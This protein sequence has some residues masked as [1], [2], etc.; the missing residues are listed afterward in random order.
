[1]VATNDNKPR[2]PL[3]QVVATPAALEMLQRHGRTP[4]EFITRH[5]QGDWG[6]LCEEDRNTNETAL[7][8]SSRLFSAYKLSEDDRIWIITEADRSSTCVL[9]PECY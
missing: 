3:G 7:N 8:D 5:H 9:T 2:F 4:L 1:M 6:D